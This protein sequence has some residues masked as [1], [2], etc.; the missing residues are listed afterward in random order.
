[1]KFELFTWPILKEVPPYSLYLTS[2]ANGQEKQ[3]GEICRQLERVLLIEVI[4]HPLCKYIFF[5]LANW[6]SNLFSHTSQID[7]V[8]KK[9][10]KGRPRY[11]IGKEDT[12]HPKMLPKL[13]TLETLPTWS[14]SNLA[15]FT[16][17][18]KQLQRIEK[19]PLKSRGWAHKW[20]FR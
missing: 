17:H 5:Q 10:P 20:Y 2:H 1:M 9:A 6:H 8:L 16:F 3:K 11:M 18:Q 19:G 7:I 15:K 13:S 4:L 14:S 12:L